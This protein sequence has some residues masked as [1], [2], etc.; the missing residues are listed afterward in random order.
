M[1]A[2]TSSFSGQSNHVTC[3]LGRDISARQTDGSHHGKENGDTHRMPKSLN[4]TAASP[5][6]AISCPL[7]CIGNLLVLLERVIC[8]P[9][10][11][12]TN[13]IS[14]HWR[15]R[16]RH[17]QT[18]TDFHKLLTISTMLYYNKRIQNNNNNNNNMHSTAVWT[19]DGKTLFTGLMIHFFLVFPSSQADFK[20]ARS[21]G[22]TNVCGKKPNSFLPNWASSLDRLRHSRSLRPSWN[23]PGK[24]LN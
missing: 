12:S 9:D 11:Y 23:E 24:W 1:V 13:I 4:T 5:I 17:K 3:L 14:E 16:L 19:T 8:K 10:A 18:S 21:A 7:V 20:F 6:M 15:Q 2:S 22:S